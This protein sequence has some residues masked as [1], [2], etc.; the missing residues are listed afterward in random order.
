MSISFTSQSSRIF[1]AHIGLRYGDTHLLP[2]HWDT[3]SDG[4]QWEDWGTKAMG[5]DIL[6]FVIYTSSASELVAAI[7]ADKPLL[8]A[9]QPMEQ[10]HQEGTVLVITKRDVWAEKIGKHVYKR[11]TRLVT[12]W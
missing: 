5:S 9:L 1:A 3:V 11:E 2:S 6:H 7:H 10:S 12:K 8:D 4:D